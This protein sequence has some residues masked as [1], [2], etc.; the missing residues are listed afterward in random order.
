MPGSVTTG[1]YVG[2]TTFSAVLLE[3][4][5]GITEGEWI[6]INGVHPASIEIIG[7]QG[8]AIMQLWCS[9]TPQRPTHSGVQIQTDFTEDKMVFLDVPVRWIRA[10]VTQAG[11]NPTSVYLFGL[12]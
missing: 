7:L 9:N 8:G 1:A 12:M 10:I 2:K 3:G 5:A 11:P 6:Q 4:A